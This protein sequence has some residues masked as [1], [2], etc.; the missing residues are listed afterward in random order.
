MPDVVPVLV[1]AVKRRGPAQIASTTCTA[2]PVADSITGFITVTSFSGRGASEGP[3]N[4]RRRG[5]AAAAQAKLAR[6]TAVLGMVDGA[7]GN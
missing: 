6:I 1:K 3:P 7:S 5:S 4:M 2:T